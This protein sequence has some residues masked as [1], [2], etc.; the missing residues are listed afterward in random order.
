MLGNIRKSP[1]HVA[2]AT[3]VTAWVRARFNLAADEAA[4]VTELVCAQ[5]GCPPLETV[6]AFWSGRTSAGEAKRHH[7]KIFKPVAEITETD[8]PPAWL[9][10]ELA[11][12]EDFECT[13]C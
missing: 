3:R 6:I 4:L 10:P 8:L 9:K 1:D 13:C 12:P 2:A 7:F 11:V 5:P